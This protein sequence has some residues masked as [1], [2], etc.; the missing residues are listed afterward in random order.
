MT[1][2]LR[3]EANLPRR[4]RVDVKVVEEAGGRFVVTRYADG[5][6]EREAVDSKKPPLRKPRRHQQKLKAEGM[7][8]THKK[9]Y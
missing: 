4:K 1:L 6:V 2:A 3:E 5:A 7:N 8:P 9:S